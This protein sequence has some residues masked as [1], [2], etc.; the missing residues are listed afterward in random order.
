MK[1]TETPLS[2]LVVVELD[3]H[4]DERGFFVERFQEEKFKAL[5][6]PTYFPQ[7]NHSRSAPGVL[8]GVHF[9]YNPPQG[10][11]VGV[12]RGKIW[13]VAVDVRPDS[14]TFGKYFGVELTDTNGRLLW[15]P[16]GFAHGFCVIGD[17]TTDV[18]YKTSAIFNPAG[19]KGIA[20]NDPDLAID[21][22]VKNPII[23]ERDQKQQSFR[24]YREA[25]SVW[26]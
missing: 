4:G 9:Q 6:L 7:D 24:E 11:L 14:P 23:S 13:D 26:K 12:I 10:K 15:V 1:I 21:W 8:R 5:G 19:E 20:W 17:E 18:L 25:P 3:F 16:P 22:P 2:G